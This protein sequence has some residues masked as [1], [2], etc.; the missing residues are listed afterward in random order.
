MPQHVWHTYGRN[1]RFCDGCEVRQTKNQ[2]R[3]EPEVSAICPGDERDT[4]NRR[5]PRPS[6]DGPTVKEL[7]PA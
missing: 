6:A 1:R 2:G 5:R 4:S 7:D 3:W